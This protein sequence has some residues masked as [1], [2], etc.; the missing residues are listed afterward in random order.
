M[1]IKQI[2]QMKIL[3]LEFE[4]YP[5]EALGKL[6]GRHSLDL[7]H[8]R[9]QD[10]LYTML[11]QHQY[12]A[13]FTRLGLMIDEASFQYQRDLKYVVTPTT[14]LNHIDLSIAHQRGV[15]IISLRGETEFLKS[16][17]ST[18]EHTWALMMALIRRL[19]RARQSVLG[20]VWDRSSLICDE[21]NEKTIG[22]IGYGRLGRIVKDY[23]KAFSMKV[24]VHDRKYPTSETVDLVEYC[25]I[26]HLLESSDYVV[27]MISYSKE[28][29]RY[30][31]E[32]RFRAMKPNAYFVNTARGELVDET[33]LLDALMSG[34]LKGA[35]LDVLD[36]DSS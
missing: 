11:K 29:E 5:P 13:V 2:P 26:E 19:S 8:C 17:K 10:E 34:R 4:S 35:A 28:N 3:H 31:N 22:I 14:G 15:E 24:L 23:A 12:G 32:K 1:G 20:G 7:V 25:T 36:D 27:L 18:A 9:T 33:A 16:I 30:M 21:L 6:K